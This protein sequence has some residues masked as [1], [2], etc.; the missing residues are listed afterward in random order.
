MSINYVRKQVTK[1][2]HTL[3]TIT[4]CVNI[5]KRRMLMKRPLKLVY[6]ISNCLKFQELLAEDKPVRVHQKNLQLLA[7]LKLEC[8]L[9]WW[10]ISF[11][12]TL[13]FKTQL[14]IRK[15]MRSY[16]LPQLME[17]FF[18]CSQILVSFTKIIKNYLSLKEFK[19]KINTWTAD[20]WRN[21]LGEW[22]SFKLFHKCSTFGFVVFSLT[23]CTSYVLVILH[24]LVVF[25]KVSPLIFYW[26]ILDF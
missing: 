1:K 5:N 9:N 18:P 8:V 4:K 15:K 7:T 14:C 26:T 17:Y 16:F 20:H 21:M 13:S 10:R 6:E 24:L 12:L 2:L 25:L 11:I 19:I 23:I 3:A 22:G